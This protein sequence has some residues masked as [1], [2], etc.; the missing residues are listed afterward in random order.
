MVGHYV[1]QKEFVSDCSSW[2]A[3]KVY[4]VYMSVP[5]VVAKLEEFLENEQ[6]PDN[7]THADLPFYYREIASILFEKYRTI[8]FFTVDSQVIEDPE[9]YSLF[10]H[11]EKLRKSSIENYIKTTIDEHKDSIK[12]DNPISSCFSVYLG[13]LEL[14]M[15]ISCRITLV[16][17]VLSFHPPFCLYVILSRCYLF[18]VYEYDQ[19]HW[20]GR[21]WEWYGREWRELEWLRLWI[22]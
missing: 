5:L 11:I 3:D 22:W 17:S 10:D 14:F 4:V 15:G 8:C 21:E 13:L 12:E 18:V 16:Q 19:G 9:I 2:V 7:Q 6:N 1:L 20:Y